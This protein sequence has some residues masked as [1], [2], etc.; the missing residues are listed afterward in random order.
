[1][2]S[3]RSLLAYGLWGLASSQLGCWPNA[4]DEEVGESWPFEAPRNCLLIV[5]DAATARHFRSWG[6]KR[7]TTPNI[8]DFAN[9]GFVFRNAFSQASA[10]VPS[11]RSYFTGRYPNDIRIQLLPSEFTLANA[12]RRNGFK[13]ALFSENPY[14]TSTFGYHKGFAFHRSYFSY[15]ALQRTKREG[16][17]VALDSEKMHG[18]VRAW[19]AAAEDAPWFCYVHNL[20]PHS[21]Y[22][23][24][25]P[26]AHLFS[27]GLPRGRADGSVPTLLQLE[28]TATAE[29]A[30]YLAALY[31]GNLRYCDDL[32]GQ[33]LDWLDSTHRLD[34]TL[35]I[36]TADHGE[37]FMQHGWLQHGSTTYDEMIHVP[38]VFKFPAASGVAI[39][40]SLA[41][42][43]LLD[44]FPTL[45]SAFGFAAL[46]AFEGRSLL[47]LLT[48]SAQ[49]HKDHAFTLAP[50]MHFKSFA[51]RTPERKYIVKL[52]QSEIRIESREL[53]D[54]E[55]DAFERTNLLRDGEVDDWLE[56]LVTARFS[57]F[58][59]PGGLIASPSIAPPAVDEHTRKALEALGYQQ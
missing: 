23:P 20:R 21:P 30:E 57:P 3:R 28:V 17:D 18:D 29:E 58:L 11:V 22:F 24:P 33:L 13:T 14:I 43:E 5:L 19:I 34:D 59:A 51:V 47:P 32:I 50:R 52:D 40:E 46:P 45:A 35:V 26:F 38:L 49:V 16:S 54:L 31:D 44:L 27:E 8:D 7:E 53:Y 2:I 39:G 9:R 41:Q 1:V 56:S 37:A 15:E 12:F 6:Y 48:G 10:T 36:I 42:V 25:R 55:A 4:R